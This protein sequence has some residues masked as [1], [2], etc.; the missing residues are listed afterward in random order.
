MFYS[1]VYHL[2]GRTLFRASAQQIWTELWH[3]DL[4]SHLRGVILGSLFGL[5]ISKVLKLE[6]EAKRPEN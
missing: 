6:L 1:N 2:L 5:R 3:L 4:V